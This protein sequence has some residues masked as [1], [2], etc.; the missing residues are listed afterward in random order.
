MKKSNTGA[1]SG[2]DQRVERAVRDGR[3]VD[4]TYD[5][6]GNVIEVVTWVK[7]REQAQP[8][9]PRDALF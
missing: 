5:A 8:G 7:G 2:N 6:D 4:T 1:E 9:D 3:V